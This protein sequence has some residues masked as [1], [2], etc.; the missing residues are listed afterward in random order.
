MTACGFQRLGLLAGLG[1]H[2]DAGVPDGREA[3]EHGLLLAPVEKILWRD[4]IRLLVRTFL[5]VALA[6]RDQTIRIGKR[7]A[8]Q[9]H[10]IDDGKD[11]RRCADAERQHRERH[12]RERRR[13]TERPDTVPHI[14]PR[15]I[16]PCRPHIA[17]RFRR[18][19]QS[20]QADQRCAPGFGR[21]GAACDVRVNLLLKVEGEL[22]VG[23]GIDPPASGDPSGHRDQSAQH[24]W[25]LRTDAGLVV[26]SA[27]STRRIE[28]ANCSQ[29]FRS[30]SRR[31]RPAGVSV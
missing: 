9:H 2:T 1:L 15:R 5:D 24:G 14:A 29:L 17:H 20:T 27:S 3:G 12:D 23:L 26:Y 4:E 31:R 18:L 16:H 28:S 22:L 19:R 7:Q 11:G 25:V 30:A 13:G 8:A 10:R 6:H 21:M